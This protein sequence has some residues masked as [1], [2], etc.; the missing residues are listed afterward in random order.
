[1]F[2]SVYPDADIP[3]LAADIAA[4]MARADLK[5]TSILDPTYNKTKLAPIL[6]QEQVMGMMFK[7]YAN[8]YRRNA[9]PDFSNGK[10][11]VSVKY[12]LWD[13]GDSALSIANAINSTT[14]LDPIDNASSY[15]IVNVHPWSTAGPDG[16]GTG[17]PMSNVWQLV[18]WLNSSKVEVVGLEELM[19]HLRNH[20]G[21]PV[22]SAMVNATWTRNASS[23]WS[24]RSN[25]TGASP[26]FIDATASFGNAIS[27][28]RNVTVNVPVKLGTINFNSLSPT[29]SMAPAPSP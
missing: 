25:W 16:T 11:I 24:V 23:T 8:F 3:G 27:G 1:M 29:P 28:A 14:N 7:A 13:G 9:A 26:N 15:T 12:S 17:D 5:V 21:T 4:S 10:P 2:P 22:E 6:A 19:I 18:Q 20:F